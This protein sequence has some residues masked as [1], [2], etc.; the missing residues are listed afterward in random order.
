[1]SLHF[2]CYVSQLLCTWLMSY[3]PLPTLNLEYNKG[4]D[5]RHQHIDSNLLKLRG[6]FLNCL[7]LPLSLFSG[8]L[9]QCISN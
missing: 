6:A 3:E 7:F 4:L 1:M 2:F 8:H 9:P 5:L